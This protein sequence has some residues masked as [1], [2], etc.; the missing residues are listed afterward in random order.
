MAHRTVTP[1]LALLAGCSLFFP[2]R[3][4]PR[5][6]QALTDLKPLIRTLYGS[7]KADS[8]DLNSLAQVKDRWASLQTREEAKGDAN[9]AM[10]GQIRNCRAMFDGHMRN[11]IE[12]SSWSVAHHDNQL[13][14]ML[15]AIE[16][17]LK[18][19]LSKAP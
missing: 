18:T 19:E 9:E 13:E 5:T 3:Q 10:I 11:R 17:A 12:G 8:V 4:D 15:E 7:F 14:N 2:V 16:L 1:I 6:I